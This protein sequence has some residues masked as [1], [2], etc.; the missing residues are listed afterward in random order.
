MYFFVCWCHFNVCFFFV[1]N[2]KW[3][4]HSYSITREFKALKFYE[5]FL[6]HIFF[7]CFCFWCDKIH[8]TC[9]LYLINKVFAFISFS[10]IV[11]KQPRP[12]R[13]YLLTLEIHIWI[14]IIESN[15]YFFVVAFIKFIYLYYY[16]FVFFT[17]RFFISIFKLIRLRYQFLFSWTS[18]DLWT[19]FLEHHTYNI[20]MVK[21][22]YYYCNSFMIII[23][24][25]NRR[26]KKMKCK[27]IFVW[28][29]VI[30]YY[31][32]TVNNR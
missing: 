17:V 16:L 23:W 14:F 2:I 22:F 9:Y 1:A 28:T 31:Q 30:D 15:W 3:Q 4:Q 27:S 19:S 18:I 20:N 12:F 8:F 25:K 26:K 29:S 11:S 6:T 5:S 32:F 21:F 24:N 10:P 13:C 7:V